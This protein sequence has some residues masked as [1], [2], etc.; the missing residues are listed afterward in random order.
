[1]FL[2]TF[3]SITFIVKLNYLSILKKGTNMERVSKYAD[4]V[5]IKIS[6]KILSQINF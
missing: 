5:L 1:M 2:L 6:K 4:K 3:S